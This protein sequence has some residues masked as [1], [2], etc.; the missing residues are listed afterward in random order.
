MQPQGR[1]R[2]KG[3]PSFRLST[4]EDTTVV[5]F[6]YTLMTEQSGPKDL[7]RYAVQAEDVGFDFEVSSDH[8]SP[9]LTEQGHA[10]YAWSVLGA[11]AHAT[12]RV[13]LATY[14]TCPTQRYH[15][16]VVAQK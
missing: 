5:K 16:A 6:G 9:W 7:V 1:P 12:S 8:Y 13:E 11:V 2:T 4:R 14:V 3:R 10:P 15:P